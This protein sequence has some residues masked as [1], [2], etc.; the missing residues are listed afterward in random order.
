[1][2]IKFRVVALPQLLTRGEVYLVTHSVD[3]KDE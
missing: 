1:V 2:H 3:V